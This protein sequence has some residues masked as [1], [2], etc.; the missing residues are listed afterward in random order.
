MLSLF[1]NAALLKRFRYGS[2][3]WFCLI[4]CGWLA[5]NSPVKMLRFDQAASPE[6]ATISAS[7]WWSDAA[8]PIISAA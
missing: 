4:L 7:G 2:L 1:S 3:F 6:T 8:K 5:L